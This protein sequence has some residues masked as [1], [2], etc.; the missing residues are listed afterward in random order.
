MTEPLPGGASKGNFISPEDLKIM[1]DE[2]YTARG[3]DVSSG[4]PGKE[5]LA[6]L[7]LEFLAG[8]MGH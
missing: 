4:K 2:Y 8:D 7:K 3:W 6:E 5:K 1:L